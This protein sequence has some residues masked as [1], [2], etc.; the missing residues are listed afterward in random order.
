VVDE[1]E[2]CFRPAPGR[3]AAQFFQ[4]RREFAEYLRTESLSLQPRGE[5]RGQAPARLEPWPRAR[6]FPSRIRRGEDLFDELGLRRTMMRAGATIGDD[7]RERKM[8]RQLLVGTGV[9]S[10]N[11]VIHALV[12]AAVVSVARIAGAKD[13]LHPRLFLIVVMIAAVSVLMLAHTAEVMVW[14]LAYAITDAAPAGADLMYFAFVN[15]TTLG[16]GDVTPVETWRLIGPMTA[17]NGVLLF[18]WSTAVIFDVLRRAM[19]RSDMLA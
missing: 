16:Y 18:G 5:E 1:V 14:S 17:M 15:Y 6:R 2:R 19:M 10:C 12:M 4:N 9:S 11:I 7:R 3:R 8:L 13:K